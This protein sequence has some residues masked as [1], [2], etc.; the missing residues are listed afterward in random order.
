MKTNIVTTQDQS[1][2]LLR[3]GVSADTAEMAAFGDD[4]PDYEPSKDE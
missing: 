2:R 3:C 1:Q 4:C